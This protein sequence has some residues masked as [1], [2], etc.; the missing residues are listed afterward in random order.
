M[1]SDKEGRGW[2]QVLEGPREGVLGLTSFWGQG[3]EVLCADITDA[4]N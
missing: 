3:N 4:S 1:S 2:V